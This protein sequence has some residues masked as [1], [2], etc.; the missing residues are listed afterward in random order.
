MRRFQACL[1]YPREELDPALNERGNDGEPRLQRVRD[2]LRCATKTPGMENFLT[3]AHK[4]SMATMLVPGLAAQ[5]GRWSQS[6][7]QVV[8]DSLLLQGA[9][10]KPSAVLLRP[11]VRTLSVAEMDTQDEAATMACVPVKHS[12]LVAMPG[13]PPVREAMPCVLLRWPKRHFAFFEGAK[14]A[15][16]LLIEHLGTG[17][18]RLTVTGADG[19]VYENLYACDI[20][21]AVVDSLFDSALTQPPRPT[22]STLRVPARQHDLPEML[23]L[24]F[25]GFAQRSLRAHVLTAASG[26]EQ[27]KRPL[28]FDNMTVSQKQLHAS[29]Q[30]SV[31]CVKAVL[32]PASATCFCR[33]HLLAPVEERFRQCSFT[34]KRVAT[35]TIEM[36]GMRLSDDRRCPLHT[37]T[38]GTKSAFAQGV[39]CSNLKVSFACAHEA[40]DRAIRGAHSSFGTKL[41]ATL[42]SEFERDELSMLM[43]MSAEYMR[44][45]ECLF[46]PAA[47]GDAKDRLQQLVDDVTLKLDRRVQ[48]FDLHA[49]QD[50]RP[51]DADLVLLDVAAV[52][53]LRMGDVT[54]DKKLCKL[55]HPDGRALTKEEQKLQPFH[56]W[57]FPRWNAPH[58][59]VVFVPKTLYAGASHKVS[60]DC[61]PTSKRARVESQALLRLP[62]PQEHDSVVENRHYAYEEMTEYLDAD[63]FANLREQL[64]LL[65]ERP[66]LPQRQR[67]RGLFFQQ[68]L[69]VCDAE[70]GDT[71]SG[72]LGMGA[73][74]L[75]CKYRARND[76]GRLYPTGMAKAPGWNKG[77]ARSVCIQGAPREVRAFMCCRWAHDYDMANAQ[78][79]MLR[80]MPRR[81]QW[82]D[83]RKPPAL[84]ELERWC[85]D[86][87]EYIEHVANVHKLP[88]DEQ[89]H[90]EYRKDT[91][92][93]LMVRMMFGGQYESW[94]KD[95][96]SEMRRSAAR[97]PRSSRVEALQAELAQLRKDVFESLDWQKF[98]ATDR[99]RLKAEGKKKDAAAIDRSVFSRIAQKTENE[100]LT[101]MRRFCSERGWTVLTLCFDGLILQHRP[102]HTL[103]L[104][105]MNARILKDS[106]YQIKIVEKPLFSATFPVLSLNRA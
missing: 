75:H 87:P 79:E 4:S 91:V 35:M 106:G 24:Q 60:E 99:A 103:D 83:G 77:E 26:P 52:E 12:N 89:R 2:L 21:T 62:P 49:V 32:H 37:G 88:T 3:S 42:R 17:R 27:T 67:E 58:G 78:P 65:M 82:A 84:P 95:L 40:R 96:C 85:A 14:Q 97:E 105:A 29:K 20:P 1:S 23:Q 76:G 7:V 93:E 57:M 100:V 16:T 41:E 54:Q 18:V 39:C 38:G 74:P 19:R 55:C 36:C 59:R 31:V 53:C 56:R 80:Q 86:R 44:R 90:C 30:V 48:R 46:G 43:G 81:L 11:S 66:D 25:A 22:P 13:S 47:P 94:I 101:V 64:R 8:Q 15:A 61:Q 69:Q 51:T 68:Y 73:R 72:P 34:G 6:A 33:A 10:D 45:S 5:S 9:D 63:G 28:W 71:V 50:A 70:Y 98:V 102:G 92:K 104:A